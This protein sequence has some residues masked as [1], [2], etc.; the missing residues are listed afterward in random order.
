MELMSFSLALDA[1]KHGRKV[2]RVGWSGKDMW[3]K[4]LYPAAGESLM[5]Q[6][7]MYMRTAD[8]QFIPWLCSQADMFA[9]DW[10]LIP[11]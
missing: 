7:Y 11:H 4:A 9:E 1:L 2:A 5:S 8:D 3:I 10:I 6:P